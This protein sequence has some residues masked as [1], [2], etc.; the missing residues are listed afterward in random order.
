[1]ESVLTLPVHFDLC[2]EKLSGAKDELFLSDK[3]F[4]PGILYSLE[5]ATPTPYEPLRINQLKWHHGCLYYIRMSGHS[6]SE[7]THSA[8][9]S[10]NQENELCKE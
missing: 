6:R 4:T 2:G 10:N 8:Q 9:K 1:M 5:N 7:I 3:N